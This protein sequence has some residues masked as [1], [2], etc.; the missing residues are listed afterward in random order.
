MSSK[1]LFFRVKYRLCY[2]AVNALDLEIFNDL[3][4][5]SVDLKIMLNYFLNYKTMDG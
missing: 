5:D 1:Y 2:K 4:L 3:M